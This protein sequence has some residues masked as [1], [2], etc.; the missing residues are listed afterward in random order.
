[1]PKQRN[2]IVAILD[3]GSSK[4]ACFVAKVGG[5]VTEILGIGHH[6]SQ[7]VKA[8][9]ITDVKATEKS[10][11]HAVETAEKMAGEAIQ[12]VY[13][14]ISSNNLL[15]SRV[16]SELVVSGHEI[17]EKDLNK[18][19]FQALDRFNDQEI[20]VIHS[21]PYDYML[22]G[23]RGINSPLGMY[24]NKLSCDFHILS[25]QTSILL[26]IANCAARCQLEVENYMSSSYATGLACLTADEMDLGVTLLELGGGCTSISIFNRGKIIFTD[27]V[28]LGG[29]NVTNDIA[30]GLCT[31]YANA[32]RLKTLHGN[33]ILT[34][35]DNKGTIEVPLSSEE[36]S[37]VTVIHRELLTEIIRARVEEILEIVKLKLQESGIS[38]LGGNKIVITGGACQMPG[39]KELVGHMFHKTVRV[40]YPKMLNGLADST[41]GVAFSSTI[42][43]L[44]HI[45][46]EYQNADPYGL[47]SVPKHSSVFGNVM[48]WLKQNFG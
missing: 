13:I 34:A 20:E 22:D 8:G 36:D 33:L 12:K 45:I 25:S 5:G 17:N 10:M 40:G 48:Q 47:N 9:I 4:V 15:S 19:L 46:S 6:I 31:D 3:L 35:V 2:N 1:M 14:G 16:N 28:A 39:M 29:I 37:E 24:G 43:L 30:R 7:G 23:N 21:L 18:Q 26:N 42:G 44:M 32:E 27:G 38:G 41:S 11:L